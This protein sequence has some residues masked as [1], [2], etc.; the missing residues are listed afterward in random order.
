[1]SNGYSLGFSDPCRCLSVR[2][3]VQPG[4]HFPGALQRHLQPADLQVVADQIPRRQGHHRHLGGV[5]HPDAALPDLQHP[6]ALHPAGQQ[7]REHVPPGVAQRHHPAVLVRG[8][9]VRQGGVL[10]PSPSNLW[11]QI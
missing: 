7:H 2:F 5:L 11:I 3:H 10:V 9:Q 4:G 6:Q 8:K 1:M